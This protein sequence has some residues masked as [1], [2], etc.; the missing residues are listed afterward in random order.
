MD[1]DPDDALRRLES[2]GGERSS[3]RADGE[4][5]LPPAVDPLHPRG[6]GRRLRGVTASAR[7]G[8]PRP[9]ATAG[10]D[11]MIA[12]IAAPIVFLVAVIALL[13]I[14]VQSG[15]VGGGSDATTPSSTPSAKSS[16]APAKKKT[17]KKYTVKSGDSLS[18][19]AARF[20]TSTTELKDLNPGLENTLQIGA[21]IIVPNE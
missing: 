1:D 5:P 3:R 8:R 4:A 14:A 11:R 15:V 16:A 7:S 18:S 20:K 12:R 13:S 6:L 17:T 9:A 2:L 10:A 19:I 21:R